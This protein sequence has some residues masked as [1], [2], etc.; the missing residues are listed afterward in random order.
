[1]FLVKPTKK[2]YKKD[3]SRFEDFNQSIKIHSILEKNY[4]S[5]YQTVNVPFEKLSER[6]TFIT[7]YCKGF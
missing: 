7:E 1:M 3:Y 5:L 4:K 2:F 6:L